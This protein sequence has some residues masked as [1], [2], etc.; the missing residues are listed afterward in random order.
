MS[1]VNLKTYDHRERLDAIVNVKS[2]IDSLSN[3][4]AANDEKHANEVLEVKGL[5]DGIENKLK[6]E[7]SA[8]IESYI[9]SVPVETPRDQSVLK[10]ISDLNTKLNEMDQRLKNLELKLTSQ[11]TLFGVKTAAST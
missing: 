4:I 2:M 1:V 7:V 8:L 5:I 3:T 6:D 10:H 11:K 9:T